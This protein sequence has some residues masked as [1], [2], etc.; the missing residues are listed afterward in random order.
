MWEMGRPSNGIRLTTFTPLWS[1]GV[2]GPTATAGTALIIRVCAT[3]G[4]AGEIKRKRA[5]MSAIRS[6]RVAKNVVFIFISLTEPLRIP[7]RRLIVDL[8]LHRPCLLET[9]AVYGAATCLLT[10]KGAGRGQFRSQEHDL[11]SARFRRSE[12]H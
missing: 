12:E 8:Q 5:P 4:T 7:E 10:Y 11:F 2:A 1:C 3:A 9:E 6:P